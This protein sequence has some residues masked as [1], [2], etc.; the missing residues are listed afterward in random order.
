MKDILNK[1]K[2][3]EQCHYYTLLNIETDTHFK[4]NRFRE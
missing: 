4:S 3:R 1:H 2:I